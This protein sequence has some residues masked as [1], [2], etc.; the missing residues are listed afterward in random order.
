[1]L[2]CLLFLLLLALDFTALLS[3]LAMPPFIER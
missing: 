2:G 1:M 3:L